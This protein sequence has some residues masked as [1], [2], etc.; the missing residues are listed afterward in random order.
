MKVPAAKDTGSNFN[1][2]GKNVGRDETRSCGKVCLRDL[3]GLDS[4]GWLGKLFKE[5]LLELNSSSGVKS[6][7]FSHSSTIDIEPLSL[8]VFS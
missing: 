6:D 5:M 7:G 3:L 4:W 2:S 8:A 1:D